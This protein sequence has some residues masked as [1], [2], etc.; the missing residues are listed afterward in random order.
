V[1][2]R[3]TDAS[4]ASRL[5]GLE[6]RWWKRLVPNPYR[7]HIRSVCHGR[8]IDVGCGIGRCLA[9]LDG[10]GVGVDP[11]EAAVA[12]ARSRGLEAYT[13]DQLT[14]VGHDP[15]FDTLLCSHVLEHLTRDEGVDLLSTWLPRLR[16]GG[17]VVLVCPQERGQRSDPTHVR[18]LGERELRDLATGAGIV[19]V[20]IRSFPLPR[21]FGRWW[22]HNESVLVGRI[23]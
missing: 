14:E 9:F 11:N 2:G 17:R 20:H 4:Y 7:W 3:S 21:A 6:N 5:E 18:F 16:R 19:D 1:S 10:R 15:S 22:V 8:V 12:I 23:E 13:P